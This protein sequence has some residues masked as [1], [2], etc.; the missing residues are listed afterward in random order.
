VTE[1]VVEH[2]DDLGRREP[3]RKRVKSTTS[4]NRID[5]EVNWSAIVRVS[6]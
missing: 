2:A 5:A 3:L 4:A 1:E 6:P